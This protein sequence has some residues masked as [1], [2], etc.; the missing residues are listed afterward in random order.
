MMSFAAVVE[1]VVVVSVLYRFSGDV[2]T[3]MVP[4]SAS[5]L[6]GCLL[7]LLRR[8]TT[9]KPRLGTSGIGASP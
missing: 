5:W 9:T 6:V 8:F 3:M 4:D 7:L 2:L 1:V